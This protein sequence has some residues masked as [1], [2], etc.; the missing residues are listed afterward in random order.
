MISRKFD[1]KQAI[2]RLK[3]F[4]RNA[5]DDDGNPLADEDETFDSLEVAHILPHSLMKTNSD[6][7]LVR[8]LLPWQ[9][10]VLLIMTE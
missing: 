9:C 5:K 6:L 1:Q 3:K 10:F 8:S 2:E 4:G 7:E